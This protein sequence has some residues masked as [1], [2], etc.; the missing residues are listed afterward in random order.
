VDLSATVA[1]IGGT[2]L[3]GA[4]IG[5]AASAVVDTA[6]QIEHIDVFHDQKSFNWDELEHSLEIGALTGG[7]GAGVGLGARALAPMLQD[8]LP[9]F[10][11]AANAFSKMPEWMQAGARGT[12]VGGGMAA[13]IDELTTGQVNPLDVA[14]GATSGALGDMV[15]G[16]RGRPTGELRSSVDGSGYVI[17]ERDLQFLGISRQQV[18]WWAKG[19]APLG[20]TPSQYQEFRLSLLDALQREGIPPNQVDIRLQG[21]S[22]NFLSG[23]HKTMPTEADLGGDPEALAR[24]KE[25]FAGDTNRPAARPFDS[26]HKLG[27]DEPSDYDLNISSTRMMERAQAWWAASGG[28]GEVPVQGHGYLSKDVMEQAFPRLQ[29]WADQWSQVFGRHVSQAVFPSSGPWDTSATGISVH[30]KETDWIVHR[31]P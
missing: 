18:E 27:L 31:V 25:W 29:T 19:E 30:F 10:S 11:Q 20:M 8:G 28:Q 21:S 4:A 3:A 2:I 7:A 14:L 16:G 13:G 26:M 1:S 9:G 12:L 5:A 22:A 6:I 15:A 23:P 24:L 17:Q